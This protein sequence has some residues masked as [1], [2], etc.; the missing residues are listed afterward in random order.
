E[1]DLPP[2]AGARCRRRQPLDL[3]RVHRRPWDRAGRPDA[4]GSVR[5]V[6]QGAELSRA[7]NVRARAVGVVTPAALDA[8][9]TAGVVSAPRR[10][11][12]AP[13]SAAGLRAGGARPPPRAPGTG[14]APPDTARAV[15]V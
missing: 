11:A 14:G 8:L 4:A 6:E 10:A 2:R 13:A 7:G 5:A 9:P 12:P 3:R 15:P 1:P